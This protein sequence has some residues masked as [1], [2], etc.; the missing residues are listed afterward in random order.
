VSAW[1]ARCRAASSG[2]RPLPRLFQ[3]RLQ[4]QLSIFFSL[5]VNGAAVTTIAS[6]WRWGSCGL[7]TP[8]A[9]TCSSRAVCVQRTLSCCSSAWSAAA[10]AARAPSALCCASCSQSRRPDQKACS[11]HTADRSS[12]RPWAVAPDATSSSSGVQGQCCTLAAFSSVASC[13]SSRFRAAVDSAAAS[14]AAH[15]SAAAASLASC[16]RADANLST[17]ADTRGKKA[18]PISS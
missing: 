18:L 3:C 4:K 12:Q 10:C 6:A 1:R 2:G 14:A 15:S 13:C 16:G 7:G 5:D 11:D 17:A 8:H 9:H